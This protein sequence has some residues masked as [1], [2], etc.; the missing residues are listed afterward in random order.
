VEGGRTIGVWVFLFFWGFVVVM[1]E[2]GD[3]D[4]DVDAGGKLGTLVLRLI[5]HGGKKPLAWRFLA[6][7]A[8]AALHI[9]FPTYFRAAE[10]QS[11]IFRTMAPKRN[12]SLS[13]STTAASSATSTTTSPPKQHYPKPSTSQPPALILQ[14]LWTTYIQRT[15]QRIKLLDT[16]LAFLVALGALQFVYCVVA[17]NYVRPY[18]SPAIGQGGEGCFW[19][20]A[21]L[22]TG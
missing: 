10:P 14:S 6:Y 17:G 19:F 12:P 20:W 3:V 7:V 15:P 16:F 13:S 8:S 2:Y 18:S 11:T 4:V 1:G 9:T 22:M 21:D 5:T